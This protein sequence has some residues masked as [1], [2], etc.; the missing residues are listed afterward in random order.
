M[1]T[2]ARSWGI[3]VRL[4]TDAAEAEAIVERLPPALGLDIETTARPG[5]EVAERPFLQITVKGALSK[6]QAKPEDAIGLD[7]LRSEPRTV[8]VFDPEAR[9]AYVF[10]LRSVPLAA[11]AGLWTRRLVAHSAA[12]EL[13]ALAAIGIHP[14]NVFDSM[15]L[16]GL[17]LGC[18]PKVRRLDNATLMVLGTPMPKAQQTSD[19]GADRLSL[20]QVRYAAADAAATHMVAT[21]IWPRLDRPEHRCF[22]LSNAVVPIAAAMQAQGHR[23]QPP[24]ARGLDHPEGARPRRGAPRL[25]R[26]DG[27][28]RPAAGPAAPRLARAA[29][30]RGGA[31]ALAAHRCRLPVDQGRRHGASGRHA[32]DR[33]AAAGRRPGQGRAGLRPQAAGPDPPRDRSDPPPLDSRAG[34]RPAGSPVPIP[35]CSRCRK[36]ERDAWQVDEG[37]LLVIADYGQ[38]ELRVAAELAQEDTMRAVFESG[39][40]M[41][42]INAAI[43]GRCTE[44]QVT[45]EQRSKAKATSFGTLFGQSARGLVQTAWNDWRIVL[46][47]EEAEHMQAEFYGRYPEAPRMAAAE[48]E[49]GARELGSPRHRAAA[50]DLRPAAQGRVGEARPAQVDDVLQLPSPGVRERPDADGHGQGAPGTRRPRRLLGHAGPRRAGDRVCRERGDRG[51]DPAR[52]GHGRRLARALPRWSGQRPGR[53]GDPAVLGQ[54]SEGVS[55]ALPE[56]PLQ[57][58]ESNF[59]FPESHAQLA[60]DPGPAVLVDVLLDALADQGAERAGRDGVE[61]DLLLVLAPALGVHVAGNLG[62]SGRQRRTEGARDLLRRHCLPA[63]APAAGTLVLGPVELLDQDAADAALDRGV[64][65]GRL[66]L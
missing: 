10:D 25:R 49:R 45:A 35:T 23:L 26:G 17:H 31:G 64:D 4:V 19:W 65:L 18:A 28:G 13:A 15:Q 66:Y 16:V 57:G 42:R 21:A 27:R 33:C 24:R 44:E 63:R 22:E 52:G 1:P 36:T 62:R 60:T 40:D 51:L 11:L 47:L 20:E 59:Q 53:C 55:A 12:F 9:V 29:H 7:P 50:L 41:H 6:I 54:A 56:I 14:A 48:R 58:P 5:Q 61:L 8:Q 46:P 43:F 38:I 32:R 30:P 39:G 2:R 37:R 3:E 34:R